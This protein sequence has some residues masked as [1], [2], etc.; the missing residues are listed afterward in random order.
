MMTSFRCV[1]LLLLTLTLSHVSEEKSCSKMTKTK[2]TEKP[3][4]EVKTTTLSRTTPASKIVANSIEGS[5]AT[6]ADVFFVLD[7][8]DGLTLPEFNHLRDLIIDWVHAMS[9]ANIA[10]QVGAAVMGGIQR[11]SGR[12][13]TRIDVKSNISKFEEEL[14]AADW[15]N[16]AWLDTDT[17]IELAFNGLI[18]SISKPP[19]PIMALVVLASKLSSNPASTKSFSDDI[20]SLGLITTYAIALKNVD[21]AESL[22]ITNG[23]PDHVIEIP[24]PLSASRLPLSLGLCGE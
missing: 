12:L 11:G 19:K 7:A 21:T 4:K 15:Y 9:N 2:T 6:E 8:S 10:L 5:C 18:L 20:N 24:D 22:T 1:V 13:Y 3:G 16:T 17:G 23:N 14:S